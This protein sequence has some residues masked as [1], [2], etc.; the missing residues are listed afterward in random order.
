MS[1]S[2]QCKWHRGVGSTVLSAQLCAI[3]VQLSL[4]VRSSTKRFRISSTD[5]ARS[6]TE[7]V[8]CA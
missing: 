5:S 1:L 7:S 4:L 2:L 3:L 8:P 6:D